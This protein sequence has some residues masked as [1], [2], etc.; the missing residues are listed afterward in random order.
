[1]KFIYLFLT[2]LFVFINSQSFA[3][4]IRSEKYG[5]HTY[6]Y[7]R[8]GTYIGTSSTSGNTTYHNM[9]DPISNSAIQTRE[10]RQGDATYHYTGN[11]TY[12]GTT[13]QSNKRSG[14]SVKHN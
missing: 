12:K 2:L 7:N 10:V 14:Y 1:M 3:E 6:H 5:N 11:G 8:S 13:T 4:Q 9:R